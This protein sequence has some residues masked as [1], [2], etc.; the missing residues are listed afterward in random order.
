[1]SAPRE[2][3]VPLFEECRAAGIPIW[4]DE[5]QTFCRTGEFFAFDTLDLAEYIDICTIAKTAQV[6]ATMYT[7]ELN[8]KPG[9]IAGTFAG[10]TPALSAG[11]AVFEE[12][13]ENGYMGPDG[14]IAQIHY[15]FV[16]MLNRL[17]ETTCKG[18]LQDAGGLG[19][20]VAVTP[21]DG[22]KEKMLELLNVMYKNGLMTFGCGHGPFRLRFLI[23]AVMS[24]KDIERAGKIIEKSILEMV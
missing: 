20:M 6:A 17:N 12:L 8:P 14:K 21:L 9:L 18:L 7:E 22:S 13:S 11:L 5:I 2:F 1:R 23:P 15:E 19:L 4:A 16:E 3:F 24:R 10:A